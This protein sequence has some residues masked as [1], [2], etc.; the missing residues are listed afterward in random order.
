[1]FEAPGAPR[2]HYSLIAQELAS[3]PAAQFDERRQFADFSFL[4]NGIVYIPGW[5]SALDTEGSEH[6]QETAAVAAEPP[7]TEEPQQQQ[8]Q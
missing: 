1:M 2:P 4:L 5:G 7:R 3:L 6:L 8:Q